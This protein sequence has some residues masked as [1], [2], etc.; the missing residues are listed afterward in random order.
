MKPEDPRREYH[1][2][3]TRPAAAPALLAEHTGLSKGQIKRAMAQGALWLERQGSVRRLR[4][5]ARALRPGDR[6]H[7]Y[8][9]PRIQAAEPPRPELVHD[10]GEWSV[11]YKPAGLFAQGSRWGDHWS[12]V[13]Q[14]ELA[15][16]RSTYLIHRLDRAASGLML[17]AHGRDASRLLSAQFRKRQ[18]EK[19]YHVIVKG[20]FPE[21]WLHIDLPVEGRSAHSQARRIAYGGE[22]S[23]LAV[24]ITTGRKHQIRRHLAA[25]GYPV[26]GDRSYGGGTEED[27]RLQA[28]GLAFHWQGRQWRFSL[29]RRWRLAEAFGNP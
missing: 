16:G 23:L 9:D 19:C 4:R 28:V 11:W 3:V 20:P 2:E 15:L 29:P 1:L 18:V 24:R 22:R 25:L 12:L 10:Q 26:V 17:V 6:L 27:L 13:R 14:A 21:G 5:A 8:L 7:L